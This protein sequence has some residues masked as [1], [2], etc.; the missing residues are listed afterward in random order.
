MD[1]PRRRFLTVCEGGVVRSVSMATVLRWDFGQDAI[2]V[3]SAKSGPEAIFLLAEW[4]DYIILMEP[5]FETCIPK[6]YAHKIR[7]FD[8]GPDVWGNPMHPEL[9]Q[10]VGEQV[11]KWQ[12]KGWDI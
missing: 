12:R 4:A 10:M 9:R 6:K 1:T 7:V 3:S 8:V 5:K 2:P 11:E